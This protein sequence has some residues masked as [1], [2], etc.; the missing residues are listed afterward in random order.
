MAIELVAIAV[1]AFALLALAVV[2]TGAF[3]LI[4]YL[5]TRPGT[6]EP[7]RDVNHRA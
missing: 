6:P 4:R 3:F 1:T 5:T 7:A 2:L